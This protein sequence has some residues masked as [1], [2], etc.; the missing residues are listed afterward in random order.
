MHT[1]IQ[2]TRDIRQTKLVKLLEF[3]IIK[4]KDLE[5]RRILK[6]RYKL[7]IRKDIHSGASK[8]NKIFN[9][10]TTS[11]SIKCYIL[12]HLVLHCVTKKVSIN[13]YFQCSSNNLVYFFPHMQIM[14]RD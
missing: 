1:T 10:I 12:I 9:H 3:L 11:K 5:V 13:I 14:L 8:Y 6:L 2:I 7:K 4:P